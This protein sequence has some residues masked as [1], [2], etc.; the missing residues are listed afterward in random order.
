MLTY[1]PAACNATAVGKLRVYHSW[2]LTMQP[3]DGDIISGQSIALL[4]NCNCN[5]NRNCHL[6]IT[7][8]DYVLL[9]NPT[10][11]KFHMS[12]QLNCRQIALCMIQI[13]ILYNR[14]FRPNT[15]LA[16]TRAPC[17]CQL[18][19]CCHNKSVTQTVKKRFSNFY[20]QQTWQKLDAQNKNQVSNTNETKNGSWCIS[21][22]H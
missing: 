20:N 15:R 16:I 12:W 1:L 5:C 17:S 9:N 22:G 14:H 21:F 18:G 11:I 19:N 4:L 8:T 2:W 10:S 13:Q 3:Q 7:R 6:L